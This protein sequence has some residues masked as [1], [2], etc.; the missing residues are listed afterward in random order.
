MEL[1]FYKSGI[2]HGE[3]GTNITHGVTVVGYGKVN[4]GIKYWLVKNSWGGN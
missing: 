4:N 3:C 2:F 1:R